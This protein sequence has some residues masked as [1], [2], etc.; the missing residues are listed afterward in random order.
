MRCWSTGRSGFKLLTVNVFFAN[1]GLKQQLT[2]D[3]ELKTCLSFN[4]MCTTGFFCYKIE[5]NLTGSEEVY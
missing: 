3:F 2:N 4:G 1:E 5:K